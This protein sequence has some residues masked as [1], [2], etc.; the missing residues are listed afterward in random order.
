MVTLMG[1]EMTWAQLCELADEFYVD[2]QGVVDVTVWKLI[3]CGNECVMCALE[4]LTL[5]VP[6]GHRWSHESD[7]VES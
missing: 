2:D 7:V 4:S 1:R 5:D 6:V 3:D